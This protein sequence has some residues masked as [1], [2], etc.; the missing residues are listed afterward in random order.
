V[1]ALH[2]QVQL[3]DLLALEA[4]RVFLPDVFTATVK[5]QA[6]LTHTPDSFGSRDQDPAHKQAVNDLL[7][8]AGEN[9]DVVRALIRRVFPAGLRY[10]ENNNYGADWLK[11]WLRERQ[12]AHIDILRLYLERAVSE[13]L[14]AFNDAERAYALLTDEEQ[15]ESFLR[16]VGPARR[17]DVIAAL[18]TFEAE[19][20]TEAVV[21]ATVVLLNLLPELPER[22]RGFTFVDERLVV[23]RVVLRVLRR[24]AGPAEVEDAVQQALP[25][26]STLSS[27][28]ELLTT[29][30]FV[31]GAGHR[32]VSAEAAERLQRDL[33]TEI[34]AATPD[35][36]AEEKDLLRLLLAPLH[37][38]ESAR[39]ILTSSALPKLN[40]KILVAARGEV[41]SQAMGSRAVRTTIRLQWDALIRI[42]GGEDELRAV[43]DTVRP[44]AESDEQIAETTQL[45]DRY[46]SGWR[47]DF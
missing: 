1:R 40:A 31:E 21:P 44:L 9:D 13:E 47:P 8:L 20:P 23:V 19:Y 28:L 5:A 42:Y 38:D 16:S 39:P 45:A 32:L 10:I 15:L 4:I 6:A 24:L 29:V 2:G 37:W 14:A 11:T 26:I 12:V 34:R 46:L 3:V 41:H 17:E 36:L 30:G 27:K 25:R 35:K 43:L 18:E 33:E 22:P 7:E